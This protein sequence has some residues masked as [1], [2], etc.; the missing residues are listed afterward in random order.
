MPRALPS[1]MCSARSTSLMLFWIN[2]HKFPQTHSYSL[3]RRVDGVMAAKRVG[4]LLSNV[5][6]FGMRCTICTCRCEGQ[7]FTNFWAYAVHF[8]EAP[9]MATLYW[10]KLFSLNECQWNINTHFT[11]VFLA[12]DLLELC[13]MIHLQLFL[14]NVGLPK[15]N[16][17]NKTHFFCKCSSTK[18]Q[19]F[20]SD[21]K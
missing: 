20:W 3:P 16:M 19:Y 4:G 17:W 5:H 12:R 7:V 1:R 15:S 2:G 6:G 9:T 10:W 8:S 21:V 11:R 13:I 18:L 14:Q